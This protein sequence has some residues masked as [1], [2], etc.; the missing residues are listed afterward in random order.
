ME[1][2][3]ACF[4]LFA[5]EGVRDDMTLANT[6]M[7]ALPRCL[8]SSAL[9]LTQYYSVTT[10]GN[11]FFMK[12]TDHTKL[13]TLIARVISL[14]D[15]ITDPEA[16]EA[17]AV[18]LAKLTQDEFSMA[19]LAKKNLYDGMLKLV[20]ELLSK[21]NDD[22]VFAKETCSI[23]IC[24]VTLMLDSVSDDRKIEIAKGLLG[25]LESND[26]RV[27][28]NAISAIRS[29]SDEGICKEEFLKFGTSLFYRLSE[30]VREHGGG[31]QTVCR[32][33]CALIAGF[34]YMPEAHEGLSQKDVTDVLFLTTKSDDTVTRE[35]VAVTICN[36]T[37]SSSS[38][39][40]LIESG[41]CEIIA[42]LSGATSEDIQ[43]LCAKCICNLTCAVALHSDIISHGILQ[44]ILLIALVRTVE[45]KTKLLCARAVMN[46]LSDKNIDAL[47][48][49]GVIRVFASISAVLNH[50]V[51]IQCSQGFLIFSV[52]EARR[53]DVC[54]RRPVL[55]ALFLMIKYKNSK[56][57]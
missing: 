29:L 8:S 47:K 48:E 28:G 3:S 25:L 46:L 54:S 43:N 42:T 30:V 37:V 6:I 21:C 20:L 5:S 1:Y 7:D 26:I 45:D 13:E 24:R 32:N 51:Q 35:L 10:A 40:R 50:N 22:L 19:I 17:L 39:S 23:A 33:C 56:Y 11:L 18:A 9:P 57:F 52:T 12:G 2:L 15:T 49:A 14:G 4:Q 31:N 53:D 44:T 41:V 16:M 27:L 36:M 34:S 38:C 55:Q